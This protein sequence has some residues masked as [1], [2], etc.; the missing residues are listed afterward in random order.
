MGPNGE[1]FYRVKVME[2]LRIGVKLLGPPISRDGLTSDYL[3]DNVETDVGIKD[4][5]K[6]R[7]F[8][9]TEHSVVA[10]VDYST[11]IMLSLAG[12]VKT[13]IKS[14]ATVAYSEDYTPLGLV[15][16]DNTNG[17]NTGFLMIEPNEQEF[18]NIID[19]YKTTE[20]SPSTGW[21]SSKIGT[22]KWDSQVLLQSEASQRKANDSQQV[23]L[24]Q[25]R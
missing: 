18:D 7:A 1:P 22:H 23:S 19:T 3:R 25:R 12:T 16:S 4:L 15:P 6:L 9:M 17:V 13:F 20:Y 11:F 14:P 2:E 5:I 10:L 21:G 8:N 24:Q